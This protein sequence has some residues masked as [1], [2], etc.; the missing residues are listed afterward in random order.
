MLLR[1]DVFFFLFFGDQVYSTVCR[2]R[3]LPAPPF[4]DRQSVDLTTKGVKKNP[5]KRCNKEAKMPREHQFGRFNTGCMVEGNSMFPL[6]CQRLK[7]HWLNYIEE[8]RAKRLPVHERQRE[9]NRFLYA[10]CWSG[11]VFRKMCGF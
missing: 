4:P 8:V 1:K 2:V 10:V 5:R 7:S 11:I 9:G 6:V 3:N